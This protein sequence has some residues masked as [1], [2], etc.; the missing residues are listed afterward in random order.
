MNKTFYLIAEMENLKVAEPVE[1]PSVRQ[2]HRKRPIDMIDNTSTNS[3]HVSGSLFNAKFL[4]R[5]Q[6]CIMKI[7]III[8]N[9]Q[10]L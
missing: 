7:K 8:C 9:E 3:V 6:L 5:E 2:A 10:S 1:A 4:F